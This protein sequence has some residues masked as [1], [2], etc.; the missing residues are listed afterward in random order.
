MNVLD[1]MK[2]KKNQTPISMVTCYDYW[3]ARI[4]SQT[5]VDCLLVGDSLAMVMYG[6]PDTLKAD[7]EM[8]ARHVEAVRRGAPQKFIV[9]DMPFLSFRKGLVPAMDAVEKLMQA[10]ANA[11]K[12]EGIYG[13]EEIIK[14]IIQ[15]GVPIM[16]HLGLTPQS[17][18]Q[19]GGFKVQGKKANNSDS[20]VAQA[21]ALEELGAFALVLEC[22]DEETATKTSSSL[23]IPTIG[24]GAGKGTDGQVLVLHDLL[25]AS[26]DFL[27][28]FVRRYS[29]L[30]ETIVEA[31]NRY[32]QDVKSK[33]FPNQ[34]ETYQ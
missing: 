1:W 14:H 27:P 32:S 6:Y 15:S 18:H 16:G 4:L 13:H 7:V 29:S 5:D 19:L 28:R 12:L 23:S 17:H 21:L 34:E 2:M 22:L 30:R 25:G 11:L 24:I 20:I 26:V 8:M 3:S 31:I 33:T 9:A 10:G